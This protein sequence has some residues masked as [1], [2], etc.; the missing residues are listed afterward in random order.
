MKTPQDFYLDEKSSY[1]KTYLPAVKINLDCVESFRQIKHYI[2][3]SSPATDRS[4]LDIGCGIGY[5]TSYLNDIGKVIGIDSNQEAIRIARSLYPQMEFLCHNILECANGLF[6]NK[7]DIIVC[8][9]IIEHLEDQN[10][11]QLFTIMNR[12]LLKDDGI[13]VFGYANPY[14]PVQLVWGYMTK[15]VLFDKTHVHN[16]STKAFGSIIGKEFEILQTAQTSPFTRLVW[17]T[18]HFKGDIIILAKKKS[19]LS[20]Q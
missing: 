17:L 20:S 4:I 3:Q 13:T 14:H 2:Q 10:R 18:Q 9:N 12:E 1:Y 5:L 11:D 8:N 19:T 6:A 15:R 7:F 16:W